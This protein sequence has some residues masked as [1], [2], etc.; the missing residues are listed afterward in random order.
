[1]NPI[2]YITA[3]A[4]I[5]S[6][7]STD[8]AYSNN[9]KDKVTGPCQKHIASRE[10]ISLAYFCVAALPD[11]NGL[12]IVTEGHAATESP[13]ENV[14]S[15]VCIETF[16]NN[17]PQQCQKEITDALVEE[18]ATPGPVISIYDL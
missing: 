11:E 1:M 17:M 16:W 13:Q 8:A 12:N 4:M 2:Q 10:Q 3:Y 5:A 14:M 6:V 18:A 15:K 9:I 7:I